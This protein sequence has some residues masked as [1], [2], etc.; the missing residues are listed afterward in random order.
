[1][2]RENQ[3]LTR[4]QFVWAFGVLILG[5]GLFILGLDWYTIQRVLLDK[6][7]IAKSADLGLLLGISVFMGIVVGFWCAPTHNDESPVIELDLS[8]RQ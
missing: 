5:I 2:D 1:M 8:E 6:G 3:H 4:P 7:W